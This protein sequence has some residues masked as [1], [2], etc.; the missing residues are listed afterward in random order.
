LQRLRAAAWDA[1]IS[2]MYGAPSLTPATGPRHAQPSARLR[3]GS[4]ALGVLVGSLAG[5]L[6][7]RVRALDAQPGEVDERARVLF[8]QGVSAARHHDYADAL[9]AF[10]AAL[11][12]R[13]SPNAAYNAAAALFELRRHREAHARI[14]EVLATPDLPPDVAASAHALERKLR[15]HVAVL[16]VLTSGAE[17]ELTL[18]VDGQAEERASWAAGRA[19]EP[20]AH[21]VA[22]TDAAGRTSERHVEASQGSTTVIDVHLVSIAPAVLPQADASVLPVRAEPP[23]PP[24]EDH[25]ARPR[26]WKLWTGVAAGV[27]AIA[28]VGVGVSLARRDHGGSSDVP[29]LEPGVLTW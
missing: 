10:E 4:L 15:P 11:A 12:L 24:R 19:V 27:V 13:R 21:L 3:A 7:S 22:I 25:A 8:Q 17:G 28:A 6:S 9:A 5:V 23:S 1:Y 29:S 20:G 2:H 14:A 18:R 16:R 26:A